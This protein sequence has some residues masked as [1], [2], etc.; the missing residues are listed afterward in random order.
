MSPKEFVTKRRSQNAPNRVLKSGLQSALQVSDKAPSSEETLQSKK[1][2]GDQ[3]SNSQREIL[4]MPL[5]L[6]LYQLQIGNLLRYWPPQTKILI[7]LL[8]GKKCYAMVLLWKV[9][10]FIYLH[11][12][13]VHQPRISEIQ[14]RCYLS[15]AAKP[16]YPRVFPWVSLVDNCHRHIKQTNLNL[17][18]VDKIVL[19]KM[20][21]TSQQLH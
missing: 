20:S 5:I 16:S 14:Q 8:N 7:M 6:A 9:P 12:F 2:L 17:C 19:T 4:N 1:C 13:N 18:Q 11:K 10:A 21:T 15:L 3:G